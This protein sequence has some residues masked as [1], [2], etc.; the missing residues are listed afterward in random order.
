MFCSPDVAVTIPAAAVFLSGAT[1][2]AY[3]QCPET[4]VT[5]V[6]NYPEAATVAAVSDHVASTTDGKHIIA[7][8]A[9]PAVLTDLSITV[10]I[11]ACPSDANG[12]TT[13]ITF[14][15]PPVVNQTSLAAYGITNI[16]QVVAATN[17]L[18][19]F[20]TYGSNATDTTR[21]GRVVAGLQT[22]DH[23]GG[24]GNAQQRHADRQC[25]GPGGRHLLP[26]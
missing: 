25:A 1:T 3:G 12:Q 6:V 13:G 24:A 15:P 4:T 18:E 23:S 22:F 7:A 17:S 10:P 16:N 26:G 19:A 8:S 11:D 9:N 14:N 21:R 2:S 20:V 5:P